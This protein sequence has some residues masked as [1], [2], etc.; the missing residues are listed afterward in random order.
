VAALAI[1]A[2]V[3]ACGPGATAPDLGVARAAL[4][5]PNGLSPNGLA[6]NGLARNG[7][8]RNGLARNGLARNGL[9]SLDFQSWFDED[10]ATSAAVMTYLVRCAAPAGQTYSF[11][12]PTTGVTYRW[13]GALGLA[14]GWASGLEATVPE[15]QVIT[16]CLA[17]HVNKYGMHV[18]MSVLGQSAAGVPI[19][20]GATELSTFSQREGCF[21]GN[22][23]EDEGVYTGLD[24]PIWDKSFSSARA[25]AFDILGIGPSAD[26]PPINNVGPCGLICKKDPTGT[27]YTS[28]GTWVNGA[29]RSYLP[30]TTRILP[31]DVY[32]CGDGACQFTEQC[33]TGTT[34]DS[35]QADCGACDATKA[36]T[37]TTTSS[38]SKKTGK[39][40]AK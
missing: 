8:A 38:T 21:F 7:L 6:R 12:S 17:A 20:V 39:K 33:G 36:A 26:C 37:T 11:T 3:A 18:E 22:L 5:A 31:A 34:P 23:F 40:T 4:V 2:S 25:C 28:C 19:A 1:A 24:H 9:L 10:A 30:L 35:C 14:L 16:A 27:W 15:E 32:Q 29:W 13:S